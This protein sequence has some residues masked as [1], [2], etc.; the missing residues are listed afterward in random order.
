MAGAVLGAAGTHPSA[1]RP[2]TGSRSRAYRPHAGRG[3]EGSRDT[4]KMTIG[5]CRTDTRSIQQSQE[6][7]RGLSSP[8]V[9]E[10]MDMKPPESPLGISQRNCVWCDLEARPG[11]SGARFAMY[12]RWG[13]RRRRTRR[14][15]AA[16]ALERRD[17]PT[18]TG[19]FVPGNVLAASAASA[20]RMCPRLRRSP[21]RRETAKPATATCATTAMAIIIRITR[22][23]GPA[24][25]GAGHRRGRRCT[26]A[27]HGARASVATIAR[28][29]SASGARRSTSAARSAREDGRAV[30]TPAVGN[31]TGRAAV[32]VPG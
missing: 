11:G 23:S 5:A 20:A 15:E 9:P 31:E 28:R 29:R 22:S 14:N 30:P 17:V 27:K 26:H 10:T 19:T 7:S 1:C 3:R 2:H 21:R 12:K 6:A 8:K 4:W 18:R 25:R 24:S 13:N 16:A 32:P